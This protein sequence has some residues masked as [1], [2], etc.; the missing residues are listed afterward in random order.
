MALQ[1]KIFVSRLLN[2]GR[3]VGFFI[4][5]I[6]IGNVRPFVLILLLP[7]AIPLQCNTIFLQF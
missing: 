7:A 6:F 5:I 1:A 3:Y 4:I 2:I